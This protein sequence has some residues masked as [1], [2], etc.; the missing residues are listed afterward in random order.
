M[1]K[2]SNHYIQ[3][4][5]MYKRVIASTYLAFFLS[6]TVIGQC[7]LDKSNY[8]L[9]LHEDFDEV[10]VNDLTNPFH[11]RGVWQFHHDEPN[12]GWGDNGLTTVGTCSPPVNQWG[13]YYD[14]SQVS[15]IQNPNQPG[16]GILRLT[17]ERINPCSIHLTTSIYTLNGQ[18]Y[19]RFPNFKSGMIQLRRDV[20]INN[21]VGCPHTFDPPLPS[22]GMGGF[23]YGMFEARMKIPAKKDFPAFWLNGDAQLNIYEGKDSPV[24]FLVGFNNWKDPSDPTF[25]GDGSLYRQYDQHMD[26]SEDYHVYTCVWTPDKITFF[27]DDRELSS[28]SGKNVNKLRLF[29]NHHSIILSHQVWY[30][31]MGDNTEWD[32][33]EK[34]YM[35]ID[36]IK[37]CKPNNG[38]F[39]LPYKSENNFINYNAFAEHDGSVPSQT[40]ARSIAFNPNDQSQLFFAGDDGRLYVIE[41]GNGDQSWVSL[42]QVQFNYSP[43]L[44]AA[45]IEGDLI[46]DNYGSK[47]LYRGL[48]GRLQYYLH[49]GGGWIHGYIDNNWG[50]NQFMI[51]NEEAI[52][53]ASPVD[54]SIFYK[55]TDD[56]IQF[57]AGSQ[58]AAHG[59]INH[60]YVNNGTENHYVMNDVIL[61]QM[62]LGS[63]IIYKG[64]DN[65]LQMFW[66]DESQNPAQYVH[67]Y[68]DN[69]GIGNWAVKASPGSV[70]LGDPSEIFYIGV[71]N[72]IQR[73]Y[74]NGGWIHETLPYTY[75]SVG[76]WNGDYARQGIT[77]DPNTRKVYYIGNDGR[78]QF[79]YQDTNGWQHGYAD[80]YWNSNLHR[81]FSDQASSSLRPSLIF[82]QTSNRIH[83]VSGFQSSRVFPYPNFP[84]EGPFNHS[85]YL[86]YF[87]WEECEVLNPS[88]DVAPMTKLYNESQQPPQNDSP[89][90]EKS[91]KLNNNL[92]VFPNPSDAGKFKLQNVPLDV[93]KIRV[94]DS[95]GIVIKEFRHFVDEI[96]I[97][98]Y[99]H[100]I[101]IIYIIGKHGKVQHK[102]LQYVTLR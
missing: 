66:I 52:M 25:L 72:K 97:S 94:L 26:L 56:K 69:S 74:Y 13:E 61:E 80:D 18:P 82:D 91:E 101:Y 15:I 78:V 57:F 89:I 21:P 44:P 95:K 51:A 90:I 8:H 58:G 87:V 3:F 2:T 32:I 9:V 37:V 96:D 39:T 70:V 14:Q 5:L 83:Y 102:L 55:G 62:P 10:T 46:F 38:D 60:N 67:A 79:F 48:D 17:A 16:D 30:Y 68:I 71:D 59:W 64:Q 86:K 54:G 98:T 88:Y 24:E 20:S 27:L 47:F 1:P 35:D 65:R 11:P 7:R 100:G 12:W 41:D 84:V 45:L 76:Y 33:G 34:T 42:S 63:H 85:G 93:S 99:P 50:T 36:Y 23:T 49:T 31:A 73:F 53:V 92:I 6:N 28:Y 19:H 75:N 4:H 40:K 29:N 22:G 77:Y 81:S 43:S